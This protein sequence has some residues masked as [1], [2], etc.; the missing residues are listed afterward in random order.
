MK[1]IPDTYDAISHFVPYLNWSNPTVSLLLLQGS[2]LA[3]LL[4]FFVAP[5]LPLRMIM[6]VGG[7]VAI[8]KNHP[9]VQPFIHGLSHPDLIDSNEKDTLPAK[10]A[11]KIQAARQVLREKG[12]ELAHTAQTWMELDQLPDEAW[13]QG[14]AEV[15]MFENERFGSP[16]S[17]SSG[18]TGVLPKNGEWGGAHLSPH[19][20]RPWTRSQDGWSPPLLDSTSTQYSEGVNA[21]RVAAALPRGWEWIP[22]DDWR[23]DNV[24][25]WSSVGTDEYGWVYSDDAWH[26]SAPY[27]YGHPGQP[28]EALNPSEAQAT[29]ALAQA[30]EGHD[31][32]ASPSTWAHAQAR[33]DGSDFPLA[34]LGKHG[35]AVTRRRRWLRR[36]VRVSTHPIH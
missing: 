10:A 36:C 25:A 33:V 14:W 19:D 31:D 23:V 9:W 34:A 18:G 8:I 3:T 28:T 11:N 1:M 32:D 7:E 12:V 26:W 27:A 4:M 13:S 21:W 15:E 6:L 2:I 24:G 5:L 20:R 16:S 17:T 22:S 35:P 30:Q 29:L